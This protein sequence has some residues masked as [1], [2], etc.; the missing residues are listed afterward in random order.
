MNKRKK[1]T[2]LIVILLLLVLV[3]VC[4]LRG[5]SSKEEISDESVVTEQTGGVK[6]NESIA[7]PG[8]EALELKADTLKQNICLKNP[9]ENNCYFVITLM[10]EDGTELWQS[11]YIK[12]NEI[13]KPIK[14]NKKLEAG[15]YPN[16]VLEYSCYS[17]DREKT[18]L[19]GAEMKVTLW[20]K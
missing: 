13:T 20:V 5:C 6:S 7:I 12:P 15:T 4:C 2:T 9:Q 18:P 1:H 19:N 16:S 3:L 17:L 14:L 10:L 11:E 8:Y